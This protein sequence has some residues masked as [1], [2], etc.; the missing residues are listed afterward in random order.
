MREQLW[1][2]VA[3]QAGAP[4]APPA[5]PSAAYL[6]IPIAV[7][8]GLAFFL[9]LLTGLIGMPYADQKGA[10]TVGLLDSRFWT[11]RFYASA[12]WTFS[13]SGVTNITALATAVVAILGATG[14]TAIFSTDLSPFIIMNVACGGIV[15]AAPIMFAVCN[16]IVARGNPVVTADAR[17]ALHEDATI[18]LPYGASIA[19]AGG[20]TV[21]A[22]DGKSVRPGVK[23]GGTIP[24]PPG[25]VITMKANATMAVP[26]GSVLAISRGATL[27]V[28]SRCQI[29][30]G[31]L[32][33]PQAQ[34]PPAWKRA[35]RKKPGEPA[36]DPQ[37]AGGDLIALTEGA[38]AT[39]TGAADILLP[40]ATVVAPGR[41]DVPL[42][43]NTTLAVP[44]G[45]NV[46]A[47]GM[48]SVLPTAVLTTFGAGAEIGLVAVLAAHYTTAG[49]AGHVAAIVI[50]A[51]VAAVLVLYGATAIRALADPAPGTSLSS[52]AGASFTL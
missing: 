23:P 49:G 30:P 51:V 24:V 18:T 8:A 20:A 50:A 13:D 43:Q 42:K 21:T 28:D 19:V 5:P 39:V 38:T 40:A 9:V 52:A 7:G 27:T 11:T 36:P 35:C 47:A 48:G 31:D 46:M 32:A 4:P 44:S 22:S 33:P 26:S 15:A 14:V 2:A 17:L 45:T 29:A 16:V 3:G 25:S 12:A 37:I 41:H 1:L 34:K 6:W 10:R